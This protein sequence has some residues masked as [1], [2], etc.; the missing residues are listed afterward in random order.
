MPLY[1]SCKLPIRD[2]GFLSCLSYNAWLFHP[3]I[4]KGFVDQLQTVVPFGNNK[5]DERLLLLLFCDK[6]GKLIG[7]LSSL[8]IEVTSQVNSIVWDT[9]VPGKALNSPLVCI[10][11]KP[12]ILYP[13]KRQYP[14]KLEAQRG[15]GP[16]ITKFLQ[17]WLLRP[18]ESACNTLVLPV[19]KPNSDYRFVQ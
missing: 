12:G 8:P 13:W 1:L 6:R 14:L 3:F 9:E 18:R 19:E 17:F 7:D 15:I 16:L 11:L 4:G 5:A 10:Q 2:F